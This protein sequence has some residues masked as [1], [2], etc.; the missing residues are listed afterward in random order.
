MTHKELDA[1]VKDAFGKKIPFSINVYQNT[2]DQIL[3]IKKGKDRLEMLESLFLF[4]FYGI[5]EPF[6][7]ICKKYAYNSI[8]DMVKRQR[9]GWENGTGNYQK[10]EKK[11]E[12]TNQNE[13]KSS[14]FF[15]KNEKYES[16]NTSLSE[17]KVSF[18][19]PPI[20]NNK[21]INNKKENNKE[22]ESGIELVRH[23]RIMAYKSNHPQLEIGC[24]L[25][26]W[27][28]VKCTG[29]NPNHNMN[30]ELGDEIIHI[31]PINKYYKLH[32]G[33]FYSTPSSSRFNC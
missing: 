16:L 13:Q 12:K 4:A 31:I 14:L 11:E 28:D 3:K 30:C 33:T 21:D 18:T 8:Y 25:F 10:K 9:I 24:K 1:Y 27:N 22:K 23:N 6:K 2:I 15:Q 17:E 7:E 20:Y 19:T 5:E 32:N 26:N 29:W